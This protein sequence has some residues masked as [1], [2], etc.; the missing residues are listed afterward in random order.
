MSAPSPA[1]TS[2][3]GSAEELKLADI[4]TLT[5]A[6]TGGAI[7][8]ASAVDAPAPP[9]GSAEELTSADSGT[10]LTSADAGG[11]VGG[12][13]AVDSDAGG[14]AGATIVFKRGLRV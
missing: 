12:A 4:G 10:E 11:A 3:E 1:L 13:S 8:G 9:A 7:S 5:S 14:A 6:D 2:P